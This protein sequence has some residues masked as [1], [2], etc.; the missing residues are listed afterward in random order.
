[1]AVVMGI[2]NGLD[3]DRCVGDSEKLAAELCGNISL[4]S[5]DK[6]NWMAVVMHNDDVRV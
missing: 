1:M 6:S 5:G 4:S 2:L 3:G